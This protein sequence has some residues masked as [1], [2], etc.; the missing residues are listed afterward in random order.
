MKK[1]F[2]IVVIAV[3]IFAVSGCAA[4]R[5]RKADEHNTK[6]ER[7][8]NDQRQYKKTFDEEMKR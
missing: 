6:R 3:A 4:S 1:I 8:D 2:L 7:L 5:Q